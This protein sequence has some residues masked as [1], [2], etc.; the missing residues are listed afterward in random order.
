M[1]LY[2]TYSSPS[3]SYILLCFIFKDFKL[4]KSD[5]YDKKVDSKSWLPSRES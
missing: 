1:A 4:V 5:S 3:L 2:L